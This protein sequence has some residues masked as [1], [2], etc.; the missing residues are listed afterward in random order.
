LNDD[1]SFGI[2]EVHYD[3]NEIPKGYTQN[4][5]EILTYKSYGKDPIESVEWQLNKMKLALEKPVLDY[6]NFPKIYLKYYRKKK[7]IALNNI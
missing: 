6:D 5:I 2:Y 3:D 1:V 7:L 4:P